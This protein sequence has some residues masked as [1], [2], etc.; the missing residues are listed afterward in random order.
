ML[1]AAGRT[2]F[3]AFRHGIALAPN[4]V[5][6]E[7]PAVCAKRKGKQPRDTDHILG[8][9][10]LYRAV[11]RHGLTGPAVGILRVQRIALIAFSGKGI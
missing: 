6:A 1:I 7:I 3:A 4:D 10:A 11:Q 5:A 9:T 2:V 8:L